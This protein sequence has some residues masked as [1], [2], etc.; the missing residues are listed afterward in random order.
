MDAA[1]VAA[2]GASPDDEQL[3][4]FGCLFRLPAEATV[5]A[6]AVELD[7]GRGIKVLVGQALTKAFR[8]RFAGLVLAIEPAVDPASSVR[9]S[10]QER[11]T[12]CTSRSRSP[13]G[14]TVPDAAEWLAPG[15]AG[16]IAVEIAAVPA[17][18]HLRSELL[19]RHLD[20][21]AAALAEIAR[22]AGIAFGTVRVG[23]G[24]ADGSRRSFDL[25]RLDAGRA[26]AARLTGIE[27]DAD[28]RPTDASLRAALAGL[29]GP[30]AARPLVEPRMLGNVNPLNVLDYERLAAERLDSA[31]LAYYAGGANDELTLADNRAAYERLH[32]RP[33]VIVD[34]AD[35]S[36][37]TSVLG[38]DLALPVLVA[39]VAYQRVVH[40]DG[41][42]GMARAA[43]T[44]G[45][46][47][48]LSSFATTSWEELA[49]TGARRWF[50]L[51]VPRDAGLADEIVAGAKAAGF[52]A[53]V[54][55]VDIP[56]LGAARGAFATSSSCRSSS[57]SARSISQASRR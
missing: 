10:R 39:P 16:R 35:P 54:L 6:L 36:T 38:T 25:A 2:A 30:A 57:G 22:F 46:I 28:G 20:G 3:V 31:A 33:R 34:V 29:L 21:D 49:E 40:P 53:L 47:Y 19:A 41:E 13:A 7:D 43:K 17:G 24:L 52:E 48:C 1:H 8:S 42:L 44:A 27:V 37:A 12:V 15:A 50:Q 55:T 14:S 51:Y 45:T 5:G 18:T 32:L 56:V 4:R 11:S 23:V 9:R 26:P